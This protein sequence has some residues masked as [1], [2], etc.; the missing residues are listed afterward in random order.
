MKLHLVGFG[1]PISLV[2]ILLHEKV[3][4]SSS[5]HSD[6]GVS[7]NFSR[8]YHVRTIASYEYTNTHTVLIWI[9]FICNSPEMCQLSAVADVG[10]VSS[11]NDFNNHTYKI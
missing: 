6:F 4:V 7:D 10:I 8:H 2:T 5:L 1:T 9:Q 3:S 11:G